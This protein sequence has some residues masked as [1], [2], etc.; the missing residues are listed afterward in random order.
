M[1]ERIKTFALVGFGGS[2]DRL[3]VTLYYTLTAAI[4]ATYQFHQDMPIA[5]WHDSYRH[6]KR[7]LVCKYA[8]RGTRKYPQLCEVDRVRGSL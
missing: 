6:G 5:V 2:L 4:D 1:P 3:H 8:L 7:K